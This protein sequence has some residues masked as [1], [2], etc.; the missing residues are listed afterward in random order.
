MKIET[1][2]A[3]RR[4][5]E[6]AKAAERS[7]Q[8][9]TQPS[10]PAQPEAESSEHPWER[11]E[12]EQLVAERLRAA[13][14]PERFRPGLDPSRWDSGTLGS[15]R[16][17]WDHLSS[18]SDGT[19]VLLGN[20][21]TGKTHWACAATIALI[22][23]GHTGRYWQSVRDM[24]AWA[25][26]RTIAENIDE[27]IVLNE[28]GR[29]CGI[30]VIDQIDWTRGSADDMLWQKR[31]LDRRYGA[32]VRTILICNGG[33]ENFQA[34]LDSEAIY[35]RIQQ[36]GFVVEMSGRNLRDTA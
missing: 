21:G 15:L 7:S 24:L 2:R 32:K 18:K 34:C 10:S 30:M 6:A 8:S 17:A 1:Q 33:R 4:D 12:R 14:I 31:V 26:H 9:Q 11:A 16:E 23:S 13:R 3:I 20:V 29:H 35:T 22:R 36:T 19:V 28:L 5:I 27:Q 25:K